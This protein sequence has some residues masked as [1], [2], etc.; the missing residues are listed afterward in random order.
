[1]IV[2]GG[3][4]GS[5]YLND[6]G[7]YDPVGNAWTATTTAG[8]PSGRCH[9]HGGLDRLEDDRLGRV[10]TAASY[11]NDGGQYDPVGERLDGDHDNGRAVG[12]L[13][14]TRRS[15]PARG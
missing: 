1:M 5:A 10:R 15:G 12:T 3:Y 14:A 9:P 13:T 8:A 2:W 6:G 11:L 4:D 7:Q